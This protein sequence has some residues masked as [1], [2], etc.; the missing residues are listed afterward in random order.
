[1]MTTD[2]APHDRHRIHHAAAVQ[3][4]QAHRPRKARAGRYHHRQFGIA[5]AGEIVE[6]PQRPPFGRVL[7]EFGM[8]VLWFALWLLN[9]AATALGFAAMGNLLASRGLATG[10]DTTSWLVVGGVFH[11][12]ISAVEQHL[13]RGDYE[14]PEGV[15]A[16]VRAFFSN[17]DRMRLGLAVFIGAID[18]LS[19]AYYIRRILY[20]LVDPMFGW[21]LVA[22]LLAGLIALSAEPMLRNFGGKLISL[23]R[24][25]N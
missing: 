4:Q 13:W 12:F 11:L 6:R 19:T 21:T 3:P 5:K 10:M 23:F 7:A 24:E 1:M 18:S 2:N 25:A 15:G 22:G 8:L 16:R 20:V 14:Q 9:G 17:A